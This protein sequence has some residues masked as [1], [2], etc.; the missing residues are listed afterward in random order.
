MRIRK[1][2]MVELRPEQNGALRLGLKDIQMVFEFKSHA[3]KC[4]KHLR[5]AVN[6]IYADG[7]DIEITLQELE[8]YQVPMFM[9]FI[10]PKS[11]LD[12]A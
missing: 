12:G 10:P 1:V 6:K 4:Y 3:E 8:V 5:E 9:E 2:Y 7:D 11:D